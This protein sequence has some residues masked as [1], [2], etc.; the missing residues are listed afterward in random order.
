MQLVET[1]HHKIRSSSW[2]APKYACKGT[3]RKVWWREDIDEPKPGENLW[4]PQ[5][6]GSMHPA[7]EGVDYKVLINTAGDNKLGEITLAN[8]GIP[9]QPY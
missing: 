6:G 7:K 2:E 8:I 1:A 3:C 9:N 4:C 5:C